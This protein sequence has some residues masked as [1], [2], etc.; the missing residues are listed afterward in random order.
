MED[1]LKFL[2]Q[3]RNKLVREANAILVLIQER[4]QLYGSVVQ[5]MQL[6]GKEE[7]EINLNDGGKHMVVFEPLGQGDDPTAV[8]LVLK[9]IK[10]YT[11]EEYQA[12]GT[13]EEN[14]D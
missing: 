4:S 13:G 1:N 6:L 5:L 10:P 2:I 9:E 3:Q 12:V 14:N 7:V 8:K 11:K